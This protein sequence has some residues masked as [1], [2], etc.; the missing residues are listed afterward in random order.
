MGEKLTYTRQVDI[1]AIGCIFFELAFN[2]KAFSDDMS[3]H[4]YAFSKNPPEI[5]SVLELDFGNSL[6]IENTARQA[7]SIL[8]YGMLELSPNDRPIA[9]QLNDLFSI[10]CNRAIR[11]V[12]ATKNRIE[13]LR[14][15]SSLIAEGI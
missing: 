8:I 1:W 11:V 9:S 4:G 15:L 5:P 3:V 6:E 12:H 13:A 14:V 2:R 7:L 10:D